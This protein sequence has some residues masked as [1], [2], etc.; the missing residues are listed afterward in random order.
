MA[1]RPQVEY[2]GHDIH[3][4]RVAKDQHQH[5][6]LYFFHGPSI[7]VVTSGLLKNQG[8]VPQSDIDRALKY[9]ADWLERFGGHA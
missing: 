9:R 1:R 6:L 8:K 2:L 4:L 7:I 5:R 3:E